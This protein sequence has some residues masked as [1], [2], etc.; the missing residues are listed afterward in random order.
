MLT[1]RYMLVILM[2]ALRLKDELF[3]ATIF[4]FSTH[5]I[6]GN[7]WSE[8]LRIKHSHV[9][10]DAS[11]NGWKKVCWSRIFRTAKDELPSLEPCI[12]QPY[13]S[14]LPPSFISK[15]FRYSPPNCLMIF[16]TAGLP[17]IWTLPDVIV[18]KKGLCK[19]GCILS[20]ALTHVESS[21]RCEVF[22]KCSSGCIESWPLAKV[23]T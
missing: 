21:G 22:F 9:L 19:D 7:R 20:T 13:S 4:S 18:C 8:R 11:R 17:L 14:T 1:T 10:H 15:G 6:Y 12:I 3:A 23:R 5:D 16:S 2:G